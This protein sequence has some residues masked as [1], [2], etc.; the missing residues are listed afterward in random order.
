[1][2]LQKAQGHVNE[3]RSAGTQPPQFPNIQDDQ[4]SPVGLI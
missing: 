1:M 4:H 3:D 2:T